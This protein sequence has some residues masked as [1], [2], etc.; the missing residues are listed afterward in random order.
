[1]LDARF[2]RFLMVGG[3]NTLFGYSLFAVLLYVGM[4]YA[5]ATALATIGGVLFNYKTTGALVFGHRGNER[6]WRF[7]AVYGVL[8]VINTAFLWWANRLGMNLYW[9]GFLLILPMA[10]LGFMLNRGFVFNL[11]DKTLS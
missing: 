4:H 2:I 7:I 11:P 5:L 8:Y 3:L 10:L 9:A 1:M 6:L